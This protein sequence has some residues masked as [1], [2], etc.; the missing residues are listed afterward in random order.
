MNKHHLSAVAL[1]VSAAIATS[2]ALSEEPLFPADAFDVK[3]PSQKEI[4]QPQYTDGHNGQWHDPDP[5]RDH[6]VQR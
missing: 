1:A 5:A 2:A 3:A 4:T 6:H